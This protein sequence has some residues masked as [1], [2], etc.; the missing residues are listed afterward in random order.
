MGRPVGCRPAE[1]DGRFD[2]L[3]VLVSTAC[4]SGAGV[5]GSD[6]CTVG[7]ADRL[8]QLKRLDRKDP[9]CAVPG[10]APGAGLTAGLDAAPTTSAL[11]CGD[12]ECTARRSIESVRATAAGGSA[13]AS[14]RVAALGE[15]CEE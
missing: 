10:E 11:V 9:R 13:G 7:V 5:A 15:Y 4:V 2:S 8:P 3:R 12:E 6:V 1:K 14:R